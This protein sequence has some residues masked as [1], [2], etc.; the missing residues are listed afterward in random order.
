MLRGQ[1]A[2]ITGAGSGLGAALATR[3]ANEGANVALLDIDGKRAQEIAGRLPSHQT[4]ALQAD[5]R[6]P[7][8]LQAAVAATIETFG[9]LDTVIP[10]AG[11]WDYNRSVTRHSGAELA[12]VFDEVFAINVKGYLLT[13]EATWRELVKTRGSIIMT[14]SNAAFY[15]AGGGPIYTASKF[16]DRGLM[17]QFAYELAPKV[18]V[19]AVAV[20]G[21]RTDLRGP[22]ALGLETRSFQ[23]TLDRRPA[24][25]NP[26]IPLHDISTEPETFTGPY[27]MLASSREAGN[28][29]GA[30]INADGGIAARG[31]QNSAGGDEL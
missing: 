5:V 27:V 13:V 29:T 7:D 11:I 31:F 25:S 26:Y 4:L 10:N 20:G 14:L 8:D 28:I 17:L 3:F 19:N 15:A 21:M 1:T 24:R 22:A 6:E 2:I 16:A 30:I 18:R 12:Q 9:K 23:Q